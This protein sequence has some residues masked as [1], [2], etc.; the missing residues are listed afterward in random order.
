MDGEL[1]AIPSSTVGTSGGE[2]SD[3]ETPDSCREIFD[4]AFPTY[5]AMG[6]TYDE[7]Y[8]EDHTLVIAYRRAYERKLEQENQKLWLMGA[9]VYQ[10]VARVAPLLIPFNSHPKA[11]PYLDK[12]FPLFGKD[13][14]DK[15]LESKAVLEKGFAYM[16]TQMIKVNKKFG[17]FKE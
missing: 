14:P 9:Y 13:E 12:P 3:T 17:A 2:G 16:Q 11:E 7:F 8:R 1:T 5:L 15:A 10:A 6:M 4:K